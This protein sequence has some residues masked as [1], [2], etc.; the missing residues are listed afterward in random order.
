MYIIPNFVNKS[1]T[2]CKYLAVGV[3][4]CVFIFNLYIVAENKEY[5]K[6]KVGNSLLRELWL[7]LCNLSRFFV[8]FAILFLSIK[9]LNV[10]T[11]WWLGDS[12]V[13]GITSALEGILIVLF[14]FALVLHLVNFFTEGLITGFRILSAMFVLFL[15]GFS[16]IMTFFLGSAG[17]KLIIDWLFSDNYIEYIKLKM[18]YDDERIKQ[19]K[20]KL[21]SIKIKFT[22]DFNF[23]LFALNLSMIIRKVVSPELKSLLLYCMKSFSYRAGGSVQDTPIV[24]RMLIG[25]LT[26]AVSVI[27]YSILKYL[28]GKY[29][30]NKILDNKSN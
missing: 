19:I 10:V 24:D 20:T 5:F 4:I 29:L 14:A 16:D 7:L 8:N 15:A 2:V 11:S 23:V 25:L 26:I 9:L 13:Q 21:D 18:K 30:G 27:W 22:A 12:D 6:Y 3:L 28:F 17:A 1:Q